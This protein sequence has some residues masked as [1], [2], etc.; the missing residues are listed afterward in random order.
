VT[1]T[2]VDSGDGISPE[3]LPHIFERFRQGSTERDAWRGG[4][5]LGL[6]IA[7]DI[8]ERH[9]GTVTAESGGQG[10]G[11]RFTVTLPGEVPALPSG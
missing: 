8:V 6:A 4:L 10:R 9:G 5:G 1:V 2:V 11:S 7:R 3:L